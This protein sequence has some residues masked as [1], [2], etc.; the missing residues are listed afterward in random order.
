MNY[1]KYLIVC[2]FDRTWADTFSPSPN[3]ID[4]NKAYTYAVQSIFGEAGLEVYAKMGG[5]QN[6]APVELIETILLSEDREYL[7]KKAKK[8]F[9]ENN[10]FLKELI[11]KGKGFPLEWQAGHFW[12]PNGVITEILVR[13]KLQYLM[14]EIGKSWPCLYQGIREFLKAISEMNA[15]EIDIQL[16]VISSGHEKFIQKVFK[17]WGI[18]CPK[19]LVTDDDMRGRNGYPKEMS[20]RIKPSVTLF[21]LAHLKWFHSIY[22]VNTNQLQLVRFLMESRKRMIYFGDDPIKDGKLA[23][24]ACVPFGWFNQDKRLNSSLAGEFFSFND[25]QIMTEF[26]SKKNT[27]KAFEEGKSFKEIIQ[28]LL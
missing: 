6:K 12:N 10:N 1:I 15:N 16:A 7:I 14:G 18:S 5:L 3:G 22:K 8:F 4:V 21:D 24:V 13:K 28:P 17:V 23:E 25:W 27:V 26:F 11:P 9:Q 20:A 19:I 2:D